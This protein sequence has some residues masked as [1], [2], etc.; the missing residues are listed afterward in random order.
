LRAVPPESL[1]HARNSLDIGG[2]AN[3]S[4]DALSLDRRGAVC[5]R[6]DQRGDTHRDRFIELGGDLQLLLLRQNHRQA[7][8]AHHIQRLGAG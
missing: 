3:H 1:E 5:G 6:H 7:R 4:P 8:T 2:I